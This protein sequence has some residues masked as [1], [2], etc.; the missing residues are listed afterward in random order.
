MYDDHPWQAGP[1]PVSNSLQAEGNPYLAD[2]LEADERR[3]VG[4]F[5]NQELL[6]E[7]LSYVQQIGFP[8]QTL[9]ILTR[10]ADTYAAEGHLG[11]LTSPLRG[12]PPF[13][14]GGNHVSLPE[15]G[16]ALVMGPDAD[17]LTQIINASSQPTP[18]KVLAHLG[19][20]PETAG[21]YSHQLVN[22]AY[23]VTLRGHHQDLLQV[24]STL[25][26]HG[27]QDWGIYGVRHG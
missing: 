1:S 15:L 26:E 27:M 4:T 8:L 3:I 14:S 24:A 22:G 12:I 18:A 5:R 2:A 13:I 20:P 10:E 21:L 23:L 25:G 9:A 16:S 11:H 17:A 7:A 19:I 6:V